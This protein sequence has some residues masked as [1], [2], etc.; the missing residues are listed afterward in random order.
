MSGIDTKL[1]EK[2][3]NGGTFIIYVEA[4]FS[5]CTC[6]QLPLLGILWLFKVP[7]NVVGGC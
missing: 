5:C 2:K 4:S 1:I 3:D 7:I 6:Q